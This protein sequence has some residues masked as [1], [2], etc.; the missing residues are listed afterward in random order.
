MTGTTLPIPPKLKS[1]EFMLEVLALSLYGGANDDVVVYENEQHDVRRWVEV[2]RIV[3]NYKGELFLVYYEN[4]LTEDQYTEPWEY[5]DPEVERCESY[6][7]T[8]T[9]YRALE[10]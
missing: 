7:E 8:V 5:S 2:R 10:V 4:G 3:F 9:K 6:E 1:R